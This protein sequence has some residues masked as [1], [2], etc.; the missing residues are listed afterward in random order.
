RLIHE[1][2]RRAGAPYITVNC[3][4]IPREL[5]ASEMFGHERGAF[6]GATEAR[7][8]YFAQAHTGTLFLDEIGEMPLEMQP[9]LLRALETRTV[10]RVGGTGDRA[11]NVRL[12]CATNRLDNLGTPQSTLR[13]DIYHRVATVVLHL[14]PLRHRMGDLTAIVEARLAHAAPQFGK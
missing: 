3:G 7:D 12:I 11:V 13:P 14:P 2:S 5:I 10:R 1:H 6:T 9:H 8:G 4:A